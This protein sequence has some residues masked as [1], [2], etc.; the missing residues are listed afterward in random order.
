MRL[1]DF[2]YDF[3]L[4]FVFNFYS[5]YRH[6]LY[7]DGTGKFGMTS[8]GYYLYRYNVAIS[9]PGAGNNARLYGY[10]S[11]FGLFITF[12]TIPVVLLGRKLLEKMQENVEF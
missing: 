5:G 7:S 3:Y 4:F 1:A 8:V 2:I 9:Q 10:I 12:I 11:A 6:V